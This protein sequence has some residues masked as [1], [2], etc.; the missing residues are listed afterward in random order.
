MALQDWTTGK[1]EKITECY[2]QMHQTMCNSPNKFPFYIISYVTPKYGKSSSFI[3]HKKKSR[4]TVHHVEII[5]LPAGWCT[6]IIWGTKHVGKT[7]S[8]LRLGSHGTLI[9]GR[10]AP[11]PPGARPNVWELHSLRW[12]GGR[13]LKKLWRCREPLDPCPAN[14]TCRPRT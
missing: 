10:T 4:F 5:F 14:C 13:S 8:F 6:C 2:K 11:P 7:T 1:E 9:Q 12:W 3:N